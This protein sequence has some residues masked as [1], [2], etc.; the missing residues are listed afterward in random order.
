MAAHRLLANGASTDHPVPGL[1]FVDDT[2]TVDALRRSDRPDRTADPARPDLL[3]HVHTHP[4][5]GRTVL[6]YAAGPDQGAP[7]HWQCAPPVVS[8]AG[9]YWWDGSTWYRP[10]QLRDESTGG[11][12]QQPVPA[13]TTVTAA[14]FLGDPAA[15]ADRGRLLTVTD[16]DADAAVTDAPQWL[17]DLAR[18]ARHRAATPSALPP[19][20][21]VVTLTAPELAGDRLIGVPAFAAA[22]GISPS[23]LRAYNSRGQGAVPE[24]QAVIGN[25]LMWSR[26][27]AENWAAHRRRP[28]SARWPARRDR[29]ALAPGAEEI[30]RRLSPVLLAALWDDPERRA[31]W[32]LRHRTREAV[33][34]VAADLAYLAADRLHGDLPAQALAELIVQ[35]A[36]AS[37]NVRSA[38][39]DEVLAW[40]TSHSP[41][42]A[43]Q[44]VASIAEQAEQR[45]GTPRFDTLRRLRV[46]ASSPPEGGRTSAA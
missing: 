33:G 9:G 43:E 12:E 23:A 46:G 44:T 28:A 20:R 39:L 32:V 36:L 1:P 31:R 17:H 7:W 30:R 11:F 38:P 6:L 45:F 14:D 8:R 15:N 24:P 25:R 2:L 16:L 13:A 34:D 37:E 18:W 4:R 35:A 27:V 3:W 21:C 19:E 41:R 22:A 40:L 42:T 26:P 5:L 29:P 10:P